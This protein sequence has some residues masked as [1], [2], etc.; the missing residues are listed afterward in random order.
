MRVSIGKRENIWASVW[1]RSMISR[2]GADSGGR[3]RAAISCFGA[4]VDLLTAGD[5]LV[6]LFAGGL[7]GGG[8]CFLCDFCVL[9][10]VSAAFSG[11]R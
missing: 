1:I 2:T 11:L 5:V 9:S 3:F 6:W 8:R 10:V 7:A 4:G